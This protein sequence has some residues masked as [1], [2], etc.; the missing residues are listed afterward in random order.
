MG[1]GAVLVGPRPRGV[2]ALSPFGRK[3]RQPPSTTRVVRLSK[4]SI[5]CRH[6]FLA[7]PPLAVGLE[8][9]VR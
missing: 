2:A 7:D 8:D 4:L 1:R 5:E 6:F 9:K 3:P